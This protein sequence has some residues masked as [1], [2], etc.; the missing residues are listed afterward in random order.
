MSNVDSQDLMNSS[1]LNEL[2]LEFCLEQII[3]EDTKKILYCVLFCDIL[4]DYHSYFASVGGN[5][6]KVYKVLEDSSVEL[7]YAFLDEDSDEDF[8][9]CSWCATEQGMCQ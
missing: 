4:P 3:T 9:C 5:S 8:Y 7:I 1:V 2:S 6:A